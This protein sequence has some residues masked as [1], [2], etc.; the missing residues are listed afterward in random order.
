V[1][2]VDVILCER[3]VAFTGLAQLRAGREPAARRVIV[4][5]LVIYSRS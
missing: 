1:L 5:K 4:V 2:W 3:R